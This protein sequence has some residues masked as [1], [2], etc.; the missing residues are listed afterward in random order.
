MSLIL[1]A[2]RKS[3]VEHARQKAPGIAT[4]PASAEPAARSVW[5]YAVPALLLVNAAFLAWLALN[6]GKQPQNSTS[7]TPATTNPQPVLP[8]ASEPIIPSR[9]ADVRSLIDET[10]TDGRDT[11]TSPQNTATASVQPKTTNTP[12]Q[13]V[14]LADDPGLQLPTLNELRANGTISLPDLSIAL[15]VFNDSP[16]DR[17]A[18][19]GGRKVSE[20]G[21][22]ESGPSVVE[23]TPYGVILDYQGRRFLLPRE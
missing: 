5:W 19:I 23:I 14:T 18:F 2:L 10:A 21:R 13:P 1:D 9:K 16:A 6:S 3:D 22:L 12:V 4:T 15:H 7:V 11:R 8:A 17:F 20:G